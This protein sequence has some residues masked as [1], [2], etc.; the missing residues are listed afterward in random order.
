M[1]L[2]PLVWP[3]P[4]AVGV[5]AVFGIVLTA[6]LAV[7]L[8]SHLQVRE[9]WPMAAASVVGVPLGVTFLH[10]VPVVWVVSALGGILIVHAT[11]SLWP[12]EQR[13]RDADQAEEAT[14]G[15]E[16][17]DVS[18]GK[19]AGPIAGLAAGALSGAFSTAGPPALVY[20]TLRGWP[21]DAFRANLQVFFLVSS[22][23]SLVGFVAT[24][25]VTVDTARANVTLLPA[26]ILGGFVGHKLSG[27]VDPV[28]FRKGV[29]IG[30]WLMGAN[31]LLRAW[32]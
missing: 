18:G 27:R 4:Q 20:A 11:W 19:W 15:A 3:V 32:G 28:R 23:L 21:K 14:D 17:A 2:L 16:Q 7:R 24:G 13:D 25:I 1:A 5:S 9:V 30:L 26:L 29:L 31:Y 10:N 8:R 22:S 12:R 6:A